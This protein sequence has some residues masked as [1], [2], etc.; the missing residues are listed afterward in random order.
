MPEM[1]DN[2]Q[3]MEFLIAVV[4]SVLENRRTASEICKYYNANKVSVVFLGTRTIH[5]SFIGYNNP[6]TYESL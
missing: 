3:G 6:A 5:S 1:V 4:A 2:I